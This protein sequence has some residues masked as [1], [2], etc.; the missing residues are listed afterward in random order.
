MWRVRFNRPVR[1][2]Y[3]SSVFSARCAWQSLKWAAQQTFGFAVSNCTFKGSS[4]RPVTLTEASSRKWL[5]P[6]ERRSN[7]RNAQTFARTDAGDAEAKATVSP[8]NS[9]P[10]VMGS[11]RRKWRRA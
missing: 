1:D 10:L 8:E 6:F 4:T 11:Y 5:R 9:D 7:E 3:L 2:A